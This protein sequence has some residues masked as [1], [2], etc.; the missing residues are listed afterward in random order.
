MRKINFKLFLV[1]CGLLCFQTQVFSQKRVINLDEAISLALSNSEKLKIDSL[2]I[3]L[4]ENK[5]SQNIENRIPEI[6][7]NSSYLRISDNITPFTVAFPTGNVVLNPQILNQSYNSVQAKQLIFGGGKI[8]NANKL[9]KLEKNAQEFNFK[10][11]IEE[12]KFNA[13]SIYYNLFVAK[14]SKEIIDS[15]I[16]L[17]DNQKKDIQNFISQGILLENELLKIELAKTNLENTLSD[18]N[19]SISFLNYNLKVLTGLEK[20]NQVDIS[21][22]LPQLTYDNFS[23]ESLQMMAL[24]KRSDLKL[25]NVRKEQSELNTKIEK[26]NYL[27][28][29]SAIFSYNYDQPN[30][31]VF[32]NEENFTGTWFAGVS[33]NWNIS[34]LYSNKFNVKSSKID[35]YKLENTI[36]LAKEGIQLEVHN[37]LNDFLNCKTKIDLANKALNQAEENFRVEQNKFSANTTSTTDFLVANTQLLNAKINLYTAKANADLA[38]HKLLKSLN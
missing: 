15:N 33:F 20:I 32:P 19:N 6:S 35:Q 12:V 13:I 28:T 4:A 25:L 7:L 22:E 16:K 27:P 11:S 31:R 36:N 2:Q 18:I 1:I 8:N 30:M 26:S 14:K 9:L 37:N 21:D 17:L 23:L 34:K 3:K 29:L 5:L 38:Y 24:D 10:T